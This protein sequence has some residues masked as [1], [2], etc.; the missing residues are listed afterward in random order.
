MNEFGLYQSVW[1][2][3]KRKNILMELRVGI[4]L[5]IW[6]YIYDLFLKKRR[7]YFSGLGWAAR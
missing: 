2:N 1:E 7:D 3:S 6:N 4:Q 5:L